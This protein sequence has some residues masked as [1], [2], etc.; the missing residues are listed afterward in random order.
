MIEERETTPMTT[1]AVHWHEGMFLRP[2]H[3]LAAHRH[4]QGQ[5]TLASKLDL[6]HNWG[7]RSIDLDREALG[8]N[9][10]VVRAL[11]ARLRD[12]TI[13]SVPEETALPAID[14]KP[15]LQAQGEVTVFLAVPIVLPGRPNVSRDPAAGVR[16][17]Q[18]ELSLEDENTG[19][20][21]QPLQFRRL[22]L[23]LLVSGA[24][25]TG[26]EVLP[27]ARVVKSGLRGRGGATG[28]VVYP[29]GPG[30]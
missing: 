6:H 28:R 10:F 7:L 2:H 24:D 27:L 1:P 5:A 11:R 4:W 26:F 22:N 20:N 15:L 21:P 30:G 8:N 13:V 18:G 16:Y 19:V 23:R 3:F 9:R 25:Q 12:G 29:A 14:L 17:L